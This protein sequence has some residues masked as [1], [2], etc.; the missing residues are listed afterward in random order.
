[1]LVLIVSMIVVVICYTY[2][3]HGCEQHVHLPVR[4]VRT[5]CS[6]ESK[7]ITVGSRGIQFSFLRPNFVPE[8]TCKPCALGGSEKLIVIYFWCSWLILFL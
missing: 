5:A 6:I 4:L 8:I 3:Q 1:M 2:A 7:L